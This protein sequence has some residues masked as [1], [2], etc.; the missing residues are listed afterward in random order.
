M[1]S[2]ILDVTVKKVILNILWLFILSIKST[3]AIN[4]LAAYL[5]SP[6][7]GSLLSGS[8]QVFHFDDPIN[9]VFSLYIGSTQGDYDL[10]F[11]PGLSG[12]NS[13]NVKNL[14]T[15]GSNIYLMLY[16]RY[17]GEWL[18]TEDSYTTPTTSPGKDDK[19]YKPSVSVT[20]QWQLSETI[21]SSYS[22]EIFDIDLFDS[23]ANLIQQLQATG[24]KV[25]CYFSA[26]SYENWRFDG[27]QFN[28]DVLGNT[29]D[30]W[31][32]ERWL[33]IRS[34]NVRAIMKKRLDLA[35]Q[36]GCDGVEPDNV[37]AYTNN[38][39]F[40]LTAADQLAYNRFI[41]QEAH[42]RGLAVGLKNDLEQINQLVEFFDFA[43][44]EQCFQYAECDVLA[45]FINAGKPVLHAEYR[46]KYIR[47][48]DSRK[49]LCNN[50]K[51]RQFSTLI[52]PLDL[53]DQFRFS[54]L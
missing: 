13:I 17:P 16:S 1:S 51:N 40:K 49:K 44:N 21:N 22:V 39:G 28:L 19:W 18:I 5:T 7:D 50:A 14:P 15:E 10:G 48:A 53:D 29:M 3:F 2:L 20:W 24:H 27:P 25:I 54:C 52:L 30:G 42:S 26:G 6:N 31:P 23:S 47:N 4:P 33:D 46:T 41:A 12:S 36:K 37:D 32:D 34:K 38:S 35:K 45:R 9:L 8:S 43:I 11:Y